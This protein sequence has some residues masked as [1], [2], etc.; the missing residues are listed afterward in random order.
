MRRLRMKILASDF[1]GTLKRQGRIEPQDL[2]AIQRFRHHGHQFGIVT[3][4]SIAMLMCEAGPL[5]IPF[6]FVIGNNGGIVVDQ[7][8][9]VLHRFD[10]AR[11]DWEALI[12]FLRQWPEILFGVSDGD[13]FG[14]VQTGTVGSQASSMMNEAVTDGEALLRA[15][16]INSL[17]LNPGSPLAAQVL[18]QELEMEFDGKI[19]F[20]YNQG[21]IDASAWG[22]SKQTGLKALWGERQEADLSVIGDG[23]N[24]LPM[25]EAFHGFAVCNADPRV[26]QAACKVFDSVG[27]CIDWL[28]DQ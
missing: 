23:L 5:Q 2:I 18:L 14:I 28:L 22:V 11:Q 9:R 27:A 7:Q 24:D 13:R 10:L 16:R 6:D 20:H 1:D 3:G 4:R 25:I 17:F 12:R 21:M 26:R 15:G 19:A 8:L